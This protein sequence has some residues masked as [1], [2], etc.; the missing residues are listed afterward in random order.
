M[1]IQYLNFPGKRM[2]IIRSGIT[3]SSNSSDSICAETSIRRE[4]PSPSSLTTRLE[5][6]STPPRRNNSPTNRLSREPLDYLAAIEEAREPKISRKTINFSSD[7]MT[8]TTLPSW[9]HNFP[10]LRLENH[11]PPTT[12]L[13]LPSNSP[14][15]TI[16]S[17]PKKLTKS[18]T[19]RTKINHSPTSTTKTQPK[20]SSLKY[21]INSQNP[22][23]KDPPRIQIY[24]TPNSHNFHNSPNS[25]N[26]LNSPK[27]HNF[28]NSYH[29]TRKR[30]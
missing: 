15:K 3:R 12:D 18:K 1:I 7:T 28:L 22:T 30:S 16:L 11:S 23:N 14:P 29:S 2:M 8:L 27:S 4:T 13:L 25:H 10:I 20:I 24:H 17:H 21:K 26:F 19:S 5:V 6:A 9:L